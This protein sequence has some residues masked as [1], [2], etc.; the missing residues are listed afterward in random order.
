MK[1]SQRACIKKPFVL[2]RT[3]AKKADFVTQYPP[4]YGKALFSSLHTTLGTELCSDNPHPLV[5]RN[6]ISLFVPKTNTICNIIIIDTVYIVVKA[7]QQIQVLIDTTTKCGIS[8]IA[9]IWRDLVQF[10]RVYLAKIPFT[11]LCDE[12]STFW[13]L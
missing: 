3:H 1:H 6:Q 12:D 11:G 5:G 10:Q 4:F 7:M 8:Y 9:G 13:Y 2:E